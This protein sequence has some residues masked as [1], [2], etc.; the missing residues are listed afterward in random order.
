[1]IIAY[2]QCDVIKPQEINAFNVHILKEALWIDLI[3]PSPEEETLVERCL[4][5]NVPTWEE[6]REIEISS[7]LYQENDVL[8]MTATMIA[9]SDS[10]N[11]TQDAVTFVL[12]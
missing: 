12:T 9:Q 3:S 8:F 11:P 4:G 1:M 2:Q 10:I 5:L 7:R 6:M